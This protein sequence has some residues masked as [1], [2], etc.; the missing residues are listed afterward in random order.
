MDSV[1]ILKDLIAF[2]TS[3]PPGANYGA[4][5]DYL[6]PLFAQAGCQTQKIAIPPEYAD[7]REGRV[8]LLAHRRAP[9]KPRLI[10][11]AHADV[12]PAQGWDAFKPWVENGRIY[13]RGAADMKGAIA[14]LLLGLTE[15]KDRPLAYDLS[16]M[17]TTDEEIGL[18]DQLRYLS[19]FL[20]PLKGAYLFDL[21]GSAGFV[22]IAG[23]G[24]LGMTVKVKGKS[25]HSAMSHLGE[26]AV[27]KAVPLLNALA[28]LKK[29]VTARRS[30]TP[31]SP[32]SGLTM[33]EA[34]LNINMIQGG[35]KSNIVP[36]ECTITIDRQLIPEESITEAEEELRQALAA[37]PDVRWEIDRVFRIPTVPPAEDPIVDRLSAIIQ[38]VTGT[39]GKYGE[40]GSGNLGHLASQEWQAKHFGSGVIRPDSNIH[41]KDE[42]VRQ[43]D[44]EDLATV[45]ARFIS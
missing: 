13:G 5:M 20:E 28:D 12:V 1:T 43:Q 3:V 26:N 2:D 11:Y 31:A 9:G 21:D 42:F 39:S 8:N 38:E 27:E 17:I 30:K 7:G 37:V 45:I 41:G 19:R 24:A 18:A 44:I 4:I 35:I 36:D 14:A 29:K 10:F 22:S 16:A 32:D 40:M 23:L 6:E 25:V 33:M 15:V 34:R